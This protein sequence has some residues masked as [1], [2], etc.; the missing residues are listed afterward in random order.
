MM[1]SI[2]PLK[3]VDL[4][5][6]INYR[7]D[8]L[9]D[10]LAKAAQSSADSVNLPAISQEIVDAYKVRADIKNDAAYLAVEGVEFQHANDSASVDPLIPALVS[11][12][13]KLVKRYVCNPGTD[14]EF[15]ACVTPS[16]N[17]IGNGGAWDEWLL[18]KSIVDQIHQREAGLDL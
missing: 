16:K 11:I 12:A 3:S 5:N 9:R 18:I 7:I 13:E 2:G 10:K 8:H 1:N 15:I 17:S 14:Q 4:V 6:A